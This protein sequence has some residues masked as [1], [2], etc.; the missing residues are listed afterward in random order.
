MVGQP[1][2]RILFVLQNWNSLPSKQLPIFLP[3]SLFL[4]LKIQVEFLIFPSYT[5]K[6]G[7]H[8]VSDSY[9]NSLLFWPPGIQWAI[10]AGLY[11][12]QA[13]HKAVARLSPHWLMFWPHLHPA[14]CRVPSKERRLPDQQLKALLPFGS[15][16][17]IFRKLRIA[18]HEESVAASW[19]A[20]FHGRL[21][22]LATGTN[23]TITF[24]YR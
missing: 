12:R 1:I 11:D 5:Y 6:F 3:Q 20:F 7:D 4:N 21:V 14:S 17:K 22:S 19:A 16:Q 13:D 8:W 18:D 24:I 23:D 2:S 10:E 9:Q 15:N